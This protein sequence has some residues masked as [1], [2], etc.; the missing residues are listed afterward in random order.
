MSH[1]TTITN[2]K[3]PPKR[4]INSLIVQEKSISILDDFTVKLSSLMIVGSIIWVPSLLVY[5]YKKW[6]KTKH[7]DHVDGGDTKKKRL[8]RNLLLALIACT[9]FGPHRHYRVGKWLKVKHWK[10]W[11][12]WL[13]YIA[14][15]VITD[16]D[17]NSTTSGDRSGG[18]FDM[19]KDQAILAF[20]PHGI[21]PFSLGFAVLPERAKE[22]FGEFRPV[23][24]TATKFYPL[25]RTI[26]QWLRKVDASKED[27]DRALSQGYRI[28][29]APGGIS[30]MFEG[31]PKQGRHPNEECII[32]NSRKGFIKMALKHQVPIIPIYSFGS[33]KLLKRLELP[34]LEKVSNWIRVSLCIFYGVC[35]L[36][37]PFRK[38]LLYVVGE[39]IHPP[40]MKYTEQDDKSPEF[41]KQVEIM[42]EQ[43]CN[44]LTKLFE[45]YKSFYGWEN[46]TLK[47]V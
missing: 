11:N 36:P 17:G 31:Y 6:K 35:G 39:P 34:L 16:H 4:N 38:K 46:K 3:R 8:Y 15:Q 5:L 40:H 23:V 24:A 25:L 10:L 41:E 27:V 30:E 43:F 13:R 20:S 7:D 37:I 32:L 45:K 47:I 21:F 33:S 28:G 12:A 42:H 2:N 14:F 9:I 44:A 19:K 26:L 18:S 22:Y 1:A 29:L